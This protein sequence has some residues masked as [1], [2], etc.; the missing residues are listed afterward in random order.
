MT[1]SDD[2]TIAVF[3]LKVK[4]GLLDMMQRLDIDDQAV[5]RGLQITSAQLSAIKNRTLLP[6]NQYDAYFRLFAFGLVVEAD[7]RLIPTSQYPM[8]HDDVMCWFEVMS[9]QAATVALSWGTEVQASQLRRAKARE[10]K[11]VRWQRGV[12]RAAGRFFSVLTLAVLIRIALG[13]LNGFDE[14]EMVVGELLFVF[15]TTAF[16]CLVLA[17]RGARLVIALWRSP[18]TWRFLRWA[19]QSDTFASILTGMAVVSWL[20]LPAELN[21][22]S[23]AYHFGLLTVAAYLLAKQVRKMGGITWL[24]VWRAC[25]LTVF[26]ALVATGGD[27]PR[28]LSGTIMTI[29]MMFVMWKP[30]TSREINAVMIKRLR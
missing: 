11:R 5:I 4:I 26:F 16:V 8:Q 1:E 25:T 18:N 17:W 2:F 19:G 9:E 15:L 13:W 3:T 27:D 21:P 14:D 29:I 6:P 10:V 7:P 28:I 20:R 24:N 22:F 23:G 12:H 30:R